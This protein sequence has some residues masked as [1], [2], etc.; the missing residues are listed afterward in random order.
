MAKGRSM[1]ARG[2]GVARL[3]AS[4]GRGKGRIGARIPIAESFCSGNGKLP[5]KKLTDNFRFA[6][7]SE[8]MSDL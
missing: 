6:D 4:P 3:G 8:V 1:R 5:A 7:N 2:V